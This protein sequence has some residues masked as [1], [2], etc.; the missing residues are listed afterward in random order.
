MFLPPHLSFLRVYLRVYPYCLFCSLCFSSPLAFNGLTKRRAR[1]FAK[2]N[3]QILFHLT[4]AYTS[5]E[6]RTGGW[7]CSS[8]TENCLYQNTSPTKITKKCL[9]NIRSFDTINT[10]WSFK[11]SHGFAIEMQLSVTQFLSSQKVDANAKTEQ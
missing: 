1:L 2:E 8:S 11:Y 7:Q 10:K 3:I 5:I 4:P 6:C 9:V